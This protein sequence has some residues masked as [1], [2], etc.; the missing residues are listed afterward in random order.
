MSRY[1]ISKLIALIAGILLLFIAYYHNIGSTYTISGSAYGTTWSIT[2]TKYISDTHK[3]S[4]I[5]IIDEIDMIAS[6]YKPESEINRINKKNDNYHFISNDLFQILT[7]AKDVEYMSQGYYN[8]M[9]G[10]ISS[11]LGFAPNFN[12]PLFQ[13]KNSS[14][15]LD[16]NNL[17]LFKDSENWFD[18][19]SIAKGYAVQ[20]IHTYLLENNF[21]DHF[22][23]IGGEIIIYGKNYNDPWIIGI[24]NPYSLL[25]QPISIIKNENINYMAIATSGEY[26]NFNLSPN[27]EKITHTINPNTGLSI[28]NITKSVTVVHLESATYADA[29]ATA[30]NAMGHS[31][32]IEIANKYEIALMIIVGTEDEMEILYSDKW[33]DLKL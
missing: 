8:I 18:L 15:S 28:N 24:Q 14:Y 20:K 2:S 5:S 17:S 32:A 13:K 33:Y 27:G 7:I 26:R 23:D 31:L 30:F 22:I 4:I 29:Y 1:F 3:E 16:D 9:L 6:N 19:S 12:D 21:K 25:E 10:K 11:E